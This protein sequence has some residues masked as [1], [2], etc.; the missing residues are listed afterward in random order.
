MPRELKPCGTPAAHRRHRRRGEQPC[1]PCQ[2][3]KAAEEAATRAAR[4]A[5]GRMI[6]RA[7]RVAKAGRWTWDDVLNHPNRLLAV[8]AELERKEVPA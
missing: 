5:S 1:K 2:L 4:T 6:R 7:R 3:A 8:V